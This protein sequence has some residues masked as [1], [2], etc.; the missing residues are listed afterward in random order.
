[1]PAVIAFED[2]P[3]L[4]ARMRLHDSNAAHGN[5]G[6]PA[7]NAGSWRCG[8]EKL[9]VFPA[10]EG[11]AERV[12]CGGGEGMN[13][14]RR[15]VDHRVQVGFPAEVGKVGR[16]AIT[17]IDHCACELAQCA[18]DNDTR[19]GIELR[20]AGHSPSQPSKSAGIPSESLE[21]GSGTA[22]GAGDVDTVSGPGSGTKE[23]LVAPNL[24]H[25]DDVGED[26]TAASGDWRRLRRVAPGQGHVVL[27]GQSQEAI[28]ES[29][30]PPGGQPR[31]NSE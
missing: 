30:Q 23:R 19:L 3:R 10:V 6:N 9:I 25:G 8:E 15:F 29:V 31:R 5:A 28:E 20:M 2:D 12:R 4:A 21:F 7:W 16:E 22:Q 26:E 13:R 18:P 14:K 1:M 17:D 11:Q 24:A 27:G